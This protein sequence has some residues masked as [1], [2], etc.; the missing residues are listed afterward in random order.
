MHSPCEQALTGPCD[1]ITLLHERPE[2]QC[3]EMTTQLDIALSRLRT[4]ALA[5]PES[6]VATFN[7][8]F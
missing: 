6:A 1:M 7:S 3:G 2:T 8:A 4:E 5:D